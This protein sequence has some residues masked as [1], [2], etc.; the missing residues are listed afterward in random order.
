MNT[1]MDEL[2][3][4]HDIKEPMA[5]KKKTKPY[6]NPRTRSPGVGTGRGRTFGDYVHKKPKKGEKKSIL[7]QFTA[8]DVKHLESIVSHYYLQS[9]ADAVRMALRNEFDLCESG[10]VHRSA[11]EPSSASAIK[12]YLIRISEPE[13]AMVRKVMEYHKLPTFIAV[14]RYVIARESDRIRLR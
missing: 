8:A 9:A 4:R 10:L 6:V 1:S 2:L 11:A 13:D 7:L 14:F 12:A 3:F 5:K